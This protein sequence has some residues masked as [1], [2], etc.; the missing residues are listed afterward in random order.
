MLLI[1][2]MGS[3][4]PNEVL[5]YLL[6]S[7]PLGNKGSRFYSKIVSNGRVRADDET[8]SSF[9]KTSKRPIVNVH[10]RNLIQFLT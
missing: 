5:K 4:K 6:M 10:P 1:G 9:K 8:Y 3:L 7:D 2:K